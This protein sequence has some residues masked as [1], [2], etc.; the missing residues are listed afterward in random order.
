[1]KKIILSIALSFS[2]LGIFIALFGYYAGGLDSIKTKVKTTSHKYTKTLDTIDSVNISG[3][4]SL[5]I[6]SGHVTKPK[7]T[8]IKIKGRQT[9]YYDTNYTFK[10]HQLNITRQLKGENIHI[11]G[12]LLDL[13]REQMGFNC[14]ITL[15]LPQNSL[16]KSITATNDSELNLKNL[17][18]NS[19]TINAQSS[20]NMTNITLKNSKIT[21]SDNT[22]DMKQSTLIRTNI[23]IKDGD[24]E[25]NGLT[26]KQKNRIIADSIDISLNDYHLTI[27]HN[28]EDTQDITKRLI[29][30][31]DNSL[32]VISKEDDITIR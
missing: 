24:F 22:V 23:N 7:L 14:V 29:N 20:L 9:G 8:Y 27:T 4:C 31:E 12:S 19:T 21:V 5:V 30:S 13:I 10:N 32:N 17:N 26:F 6:T 16:L 2:L 15:T 25:G 18:L 1:M 28:A 11:S 3:D